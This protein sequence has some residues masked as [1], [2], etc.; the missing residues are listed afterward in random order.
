MYVV[1]AGCTRTTMYGMYLCRDDMDVRK[2]RRQLTSVIPAKAGIQYFYRHTG[3]CQYPVKVCHPE[4]E[5][6]ILHN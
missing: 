5:G 1:C 4:P 6:G 2:R 3:A